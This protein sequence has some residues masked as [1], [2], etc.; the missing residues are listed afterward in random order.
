[1]V[2][3]IRESRHDLTQL[4]ARMQ[5]DI[6]Q[7][8]TQPVLR[9]ASTGS[10]PGTPGLSTDADGLHLFNA[11]GVEITTLSAATGQMKTAGANGNVSIAANA[12]PIT[13]S[14]PVPN[15]LMAWTAT[16]TTQTQPAAIYSYESRV[17]VLSPT[18]STVSTISYLAMATTGWSLTCFDK[19]T[20][21]GSGAYIRGDNT[22]TWIMSGSA[23]AAPFVQSNS[24]NS[25]TMAQA[26]NGPAVYSTPGVNGTAILAGGGTNGG[27]SLVAHGTGTVGILGNTTVSGTFS[28]TGT[29]AF[30]MP[31]PLDPTKTLMHAST[32]S[33]QN[34]VEYWGTATTDVTG[35][36]TV[37]LPGYFEALT[38]QEDRA[39]ILTPQGTPQPLAYEPIT[40]GSF[41]VTGAPNSP[42][43]WLVKAVRQQL[44][45]GT[46][47]LAFEA[48]QDQA[49]AAASRPAPAAPPAPV[50]DATVSSAGS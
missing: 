21:A 40:D 42:F 46:D 48:E 19:V 13:D 35:T 8:A 37:T 16:G 50:P 6:R 29:K 45:N 44:V 23:A 30:V 28:A 7:L 2:N 11:S 22:G 17:G 15:I 14:L 9:H 24:D 34:G 38:Q 47:G 18:Q 5:A 43:S 10:D 33:P 41:T 39:V 32:E 31:H 27:V 49:L 1:M 36:A 4:L 20:S 26:G 12:I 25:W 3:A